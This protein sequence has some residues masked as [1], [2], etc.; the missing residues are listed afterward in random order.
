MA[1][2]GST[3]HCLAEY[4]ISHYY[5]YDYDLSELWGKTTTL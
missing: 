5:L 4:L 3:E 1:V 2:K